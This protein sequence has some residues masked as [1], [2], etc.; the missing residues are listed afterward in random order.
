MSL[1]PI[2][3][4]GR[5]LVTT[6]LGV[7]VKRLKGAPLEQE[8]LADISRGRTATPV[9]AFRITRLGGFSIDELLAGN[10]PAP[11]TCRTAGMS[12][13]TNLR[14]TAREPLPPERLIEND[15]GQLLRGHSGSVN[16]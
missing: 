11:G 10:Y 13:M 6:L 1:L 3:A 7:R 8:T 2:I 12:R 16:P 5:S 14:L 9:L 15:L 4:S